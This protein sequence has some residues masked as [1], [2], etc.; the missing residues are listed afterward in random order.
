MSQGGADLFISRHRGGLIIW[1]E[2]QLDE[3]CQHTEW[4]GQA[5]GRYAQDGGYPWVGA[6]LRAILRDGH[7]KFSGRGNAGAERSAPATGDEGRGNQVTS[8]TSCAICRARMR[9]S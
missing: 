1:A 2:L 3:T 4:T 8:G 6:V 9:S 7:G 5:T